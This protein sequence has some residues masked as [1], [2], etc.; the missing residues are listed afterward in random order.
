MKTRDPFRIRMRTRVLCGRTPITGCMFHS[1]EHA[2]LWAMRDSLDAGKA[3]GPAVVG[4]E[5]TESQRDSR[6]ASSR[7]CS[8]GKCCTSCETTQAAND[9]GKMNG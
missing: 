2:R 6:L 7:V 3:Y 1:N 4:V 5:N 8:R 9:K